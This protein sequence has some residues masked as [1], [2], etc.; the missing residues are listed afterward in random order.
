VAGQ[1]GPGETFFVFN[2]HLAPLEPQQAGGQ[3]I[4]G[5][6]PSETY[7]PSL[8]V[9]WEDG[10]DFV[11]IVDAGGSEVSRM[12]C[13]IPAGWTPTPQPTQAPPPNGNT[14]TANTPGPPQT[15]AV[16]DVPGPPNTGAGRGA[17]VGRTG[18]VSGQPTGAG[19]SGVPSGGG[20]PQHGQSLAFMA[21]S[22][23]AG[24][25]VTGGGLL[26]IGRAARYPPEHDP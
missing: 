9:L 12:P 25:V 10:Y 14:D 3:W 26:V 7:D 15:G 21:I 23:I 2:G 6:N 17:Q 11:A 22:V 18:S 4:Y 13:P 20:P 24:A 1:A 8:F 16:Q 5:W 19:N